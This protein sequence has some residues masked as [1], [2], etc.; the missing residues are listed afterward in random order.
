M[1]RVPFFSC[2]LFL[3]AGF[4]RRPVRPRSSTIRALR[5][6]MRCRRASWSSSACEVVLH[7]RLRGR[8]HDGRHAGLARPIHAVQA[9]D[10]F[11]QFQLGAEPRNDAPPSPA[12]GTIHDCSRGNPGW[13]SKYVIFDNSV[14]IFRLA[15]PA[16]DF[17]L[18]KLCYV[19]EAA[20]ASTYIATM[21]ALE[22][23]YP[24]TAVVY[25]T[26]PLTTGVDPANVLRNQ[27]NQAVR[28]Y[29]TANNKFSSTSPTSR[30]TTSAACGRPSLFQGQTYERLYSG[31]TGDSGHLNAAGQQ[32]VCKGWYA[33]LRLRHT[34]HLLRR[35]LDRGHGRASQ[36]VGRWAIGRP[37]PARPSYPTPRA[38]DSPSVRQ[39]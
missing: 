34:V 23:A 29:C 5:R 17:A 8:E 20:N 33:A 32:Q 37:I 11:G 1:V 14:R 27:Y 30:P 21:T 35:N 31:Y 12:L 26:M 10:E 25:A 28:S 13:N 6:S 22:A 4:R 19:D 15:S 36:P 38:S 2:C 24:A 9:A 7:A 16:V 39:A 3:S 18:D